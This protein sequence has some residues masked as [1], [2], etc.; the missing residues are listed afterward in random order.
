MP[1]SGGDL[2][3]R[4]RGTH[5]LEINVNSCAVSKNL[6]RKLFREGCYAFWKPFLLDP[7]QIK[8]GDLEE[9]W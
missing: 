7:N 9:R 6:E 5:L 3:S 8:L 2:V 1:T 4:V